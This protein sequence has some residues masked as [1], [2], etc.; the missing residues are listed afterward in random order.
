MVK[1]LR[2]PTAAAWAVNQLTRREGERVAA[3]LALGSELREAQSSALSGRGA[4]RFRELT[5][6]RRDLVD[7]LTFAALGY[8]GAGADSQLDAVA[9]TLGAALASPEAALALRAGRLVR[10]L[11]PPSGFPGAGAGDGAPTVRNGLASTEDLCVGHD[12][13]GTSKRRS[14]GAVDGPSGTDEP[15]GGTP[16][17]R[18]RRRAAR[19][20]RGRV[21]EPAAASNVGAAARRADVEVDIASKERAVVLAREE[22]QQAAREAAAAGREASRLQDELVSAN[23]RAKAAAERARVA[24]WAQARAQQELDAA[25]RRLDG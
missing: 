21:P 14:A 10:P 16:T 19:A 20:E 13:P 17:A 9:A 18:D 25:R 24:Q 6:R 23:G 4:A 1:A 2:R 7:E 5:A 11:D 12:E 8:L 3:L 22:A 15:A